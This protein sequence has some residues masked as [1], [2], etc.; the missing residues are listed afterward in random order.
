MPRAL[1]QI[2][3]VDGGNTD[4]PIGVPVTLTNNGNG[5]RHAAVLTGPGV[6]REPFQL[7]GIRICR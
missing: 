4:L 1:I 5:G 3:G 2:N 7:A 6:C